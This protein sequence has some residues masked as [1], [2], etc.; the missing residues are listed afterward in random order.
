MYNFVKIIIYLKIKCLVLKTFHLDIVLLRGGC[1]LNDLIAVSMET[2]ITYISQFGKYLQNGCASV[3]LD[4]MRNYNEEYGIYFCIARDKKFGHC[5][6]MFGNII[7]DPTASQFNYKKYGDVFILH[8][9]AVKK[10]EYW[11]KNYKKYYTYN[12][13]RVALIRDLI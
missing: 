5:F 10:N 4:I 11:W 13:A 6:L 9:D 12:T 8:K 7:I 1:V 3:C 2:K